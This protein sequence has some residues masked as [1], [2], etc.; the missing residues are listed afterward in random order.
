MSSSLDFLSLQLQRRHYRQQTKAL[1][2]FQLEPHI[3]IM[4]MSAMPQQCFYPPHGGA[5]HGILTSDWYIGNEFVPRC[6]KSEIVKFHQ[7][8]NAKIQ[9]EC[10]YPDRK[11]CY[12]THGRYKP[13]LLAEVTT[14]K[15]INKSL[16]ARINIKKDQPLGLIG[17]VFRLQEPDDE[18]LHHILFFELQQDLSSML[19]NHSD[20]FAPVKSKVSDR[21]VLDM[22]ES[23]GITKYINTTCD[24][25]MANV[26]RWTVVIDRQIHVEYW[27][28]RDIPKGTHILDY[29]PL[30]FNKKTKKQ[31]FK[32]CLCHQLGVATCINAAQ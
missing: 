29:Y 31:Q 10:D 6:C 27:T 14:S 28:T 12:H 5:G 23:E 11:S 32:G 3:H 19:Y 26:K 15:S 9:H 17:G 18:D 30:V 20:R 2:K 21:F 4:S 13:D 16:V 22:T 8:I 7:S 25:K 24:K 1:Q